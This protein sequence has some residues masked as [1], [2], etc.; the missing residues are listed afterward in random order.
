MRCSSTTQFKLGRCYIPLLMQTYLMAS[1]GRYALTNHA[2][3]PSSGSSSCLPA[4]CW[5]ERGGT[6]LKRQCRDF[7]GLLIP[8]WQ[9]APFVC[10]PVIVYHTDQRQSISSKW[11]AILNQPQ[12]E[13]EQAAHC[14]SNGAQP[15]L[16]KPGGLSSTLSKRRRTA[17]S[18][19]YGRLVAPSTSTRASWV[20][21]PCIWTRNSVLIRRAASLS[22]SPRVLH[23]ASICGAQ[24]W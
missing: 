20:F 12:S 19:P 18:R 4:N 24:W 21:K 13:G 9:A 15:T 17:W 1:T 22:P 6:S 8:D 10:D 16:V 3:H 23:S 11:P 14:R 2:G 5:K 7:I